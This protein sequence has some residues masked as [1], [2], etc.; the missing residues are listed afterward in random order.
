[1]KNPALQRMFR[2]TSSEMNLRSTLS[3]SF[4]SIHMPVID[5]T[6]N[7]GCVQSVVSNVIPGTI[8]KFWTGQ[9]NN[10]PWGHVVYE[11]CL[12]LVVFAKPSQSPFI[13]RGTHAAGHDI[14]IITRHGF[15]NAFIED[16]DEKYLWSVIS[17]P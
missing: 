12:A 11:H 6:L 10:A 17:Q 16:D 14:A 3:V 2:S 1:M 5:N 13:N 4:T 9:V 7:E 8:L 15:A